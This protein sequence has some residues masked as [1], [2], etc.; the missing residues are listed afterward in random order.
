MNAVHAVLPW[1]AGMLV[2]AMGFNLWRA[3]AFD[4]VAGSWAAL[5]NLPTV[6]T[7]TLFV[8]VLMVSS[9]CRS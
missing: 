2:L 6:L 1:V 8:S 4:P 7:L 5:T 3:L 9:I